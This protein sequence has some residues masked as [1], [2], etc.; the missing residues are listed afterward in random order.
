MLS[1]SVNQEIENEILLKNNADILNISNEVNDIG[2]N[3]S[4]AYF[5]L[6]D[7]VNVVV[8]TTELTQ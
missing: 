7:K 5:N 6:K 4:T 1:V 3:T 8:D 2:V